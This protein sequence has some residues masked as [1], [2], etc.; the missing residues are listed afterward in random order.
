M[1]GYFTDASAA[2]SSLGLFRA[3]NPARNVETRTGPRPVAGSITPLN[4][5]GRGGVPSSGVAA[6]VVNLTATQAAGPGWL[7]AIPTGRSVP[8]PSR[9]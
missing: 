8:A 7:Q 9:T 5:L 6:V 2:S 1:F 4:P 3:L